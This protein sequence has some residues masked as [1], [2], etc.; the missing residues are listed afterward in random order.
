MTCTFA[1]QVSASRRSLA[2]H[3]GAHS[4]VIRYHDRLCCCGWMVWGAV[5]R[6]HRE[7]FLFERS[8][9]DDWH[10]ARPAGCAPR[11]APPGGARAAH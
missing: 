8:D 5:S 6:M 10:R 4:R 7:H 11:P 3:S 2:R 9:A 1:I